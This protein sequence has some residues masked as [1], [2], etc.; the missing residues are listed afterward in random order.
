MLSKYSNVSWP[1]VYQIP[2][3]VIDL[4][5]LVYFA[6]IITPMRWVCKIVASS[7]G[8]SVFKNFISKLACNRGMSWLMANLPSLLIV[9]SDSGIRDFLACHRIHEKIFAKSNTI[10]NGESPDE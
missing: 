2:I 7:K 6:Q 1:L 8:I 5:R 10:H 3:S 4:E 9:H